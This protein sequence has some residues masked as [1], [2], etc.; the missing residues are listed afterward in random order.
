MLVCD[1]I[2]RAHLHVGINGKIDTIGTCSVVE[3]TDEL[4]IITALGRSKHLRMVSLCVLGLRLFVNN[5]GNIK[6]S[7]KRE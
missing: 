5:H 7:S 6:V 3:P 1:S 2:L 4:K